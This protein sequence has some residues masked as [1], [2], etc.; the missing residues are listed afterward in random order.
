MSIFSQRAIAQRRVGMLFLRSYAAG[1]N[2]EAQAWSIVNPF[3]WLSPKPTT[4]QTFLNLM[5]RQDAWL[6][7]IASGED[8][9]EDALIRWD[10][11]FVNIIE[12]LEAVHYGAKQDVLINVGMTVWETAADTAV[13][14]KDVGSFGANIA[15]LIKEDPRRFLVTVA[16]IGVGATV[17]LPAAKAALMTKR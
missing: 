14:A 3:R 13:I 9:R 10:R 4:R 15:A 16:L 6:D 12:G 2:F 5:D 17:A 1:L 8:S 11:A 7:R